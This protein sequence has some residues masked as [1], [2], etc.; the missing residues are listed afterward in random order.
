MLADVGD[1][2]NSTKITIAEDHDNRKRLN[3]HA[4]DAFIAVA[5]HHLVVDRELPRFWADEVMNLLKA[6][7]E[8]SDNRPMVT[9]ALA[10]ILNLG[11]SNQAAEISKEIDV[12]FFADTFNTV[13]SDPEANA[14]EED[15]LDLYIHTALLLFK[16]KQPPADIGRVKALVGEMGETIKGVVVGQGPV[17]KKGSEDETIMNT[18]RVRWKAVYL[19][20]LLVGFLPLDEREERIKG[21]RTTVET[22]VQTGELSIAEDY[23]RCLKPLGGQVKLQS[24]AERKGKSFTA[25]E[26]WIKNFPL[27]PSAG[28]VLSHA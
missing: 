23:K 16:L 13:R 26:T 11:T 18:D 9:Y 19:C 4:V 25:F 8:D 10:L 5:R 17:S 2:W 1:I 3:F 7:L 12:E 22:T 27:L 24:P 6:A 14:V 15:V 28:S 21:L 20:G